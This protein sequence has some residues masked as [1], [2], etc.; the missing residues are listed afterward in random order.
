MTFNEMQEG[1]GQILRVAP[2]ISVAFLAL[3]TIDLRGPRRSEAPADMQRR[4]A[5]ASEAGLRA[6]LSC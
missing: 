3:Q 6:R 4:A 5:Q 2:R 1:N